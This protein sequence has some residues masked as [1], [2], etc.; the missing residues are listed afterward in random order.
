MDE[1][2]EL[3]L[4]LYKTISNKDID[5]EITIVNNEKE[6]QYFRIIRTEIINDVIKESLIENNFINAGSFKDSLADVVNKI[7]NNDWT[8]C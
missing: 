2:Q 7:K 1:E 3:W 6:I 8:Y 4:E 5:T